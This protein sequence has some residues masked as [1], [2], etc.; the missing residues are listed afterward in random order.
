M[1]PWDEEAKDYKELNEDKKNSRNKNWDFSGGPAFKTLHSNT[2][3]AG[4]IPGKGVE[5][6]PKCKTEA[7][8]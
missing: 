7:I 8:L 5:I 2:E 1:T 6:P 4:S 3:A